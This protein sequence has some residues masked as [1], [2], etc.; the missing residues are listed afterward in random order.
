MFIKLV[1]LCVFQLLAL[2]IFASDQTIAQKQS[3]SQH[4]EKLK[5]HIPLPVLQKIIMDYVGDEYIPTKLDMV[6]RVSATAQS[7]N[8]QYLFIASQITEGLSNTKDTAKVWKFENGKYVLIAHILLPVTAYSSGVAA[9]SDDGKFIAVRDQYQNEDRGNIHIGQLD[10][11]KYIE[12]QIVKN[13]FGIRGLQFFGNTFLGF[14]TQSAGTM[15]L[16]LSQSDRFDLEQEFGERFT[17]GPATFSPDGSYLVI[18]T[19]H[20]LQLWKKI[21]DEFRLKSTRETGT[22][23]N[24]ISISNDNKYVATI[25]NEFAVIY[26]LREDKLEPFQKI[27]LNGYSGEIKFSPDNTYLALA[28]SVPRKSLPKIIIFKFNKKSE[29]YEQIAT[30][31]HD[32]FNRDPYHLIG[33]APNNS[34]ITATV[35]NEITIWENQKEQLERDTGEKAITAVEQEKVTEVD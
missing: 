31:P 18:G 12:K 5:E 29:Q 20:D 25:D 33:F 26:S 14:K 13:A 16:K 3:A 35:G 28:I 9:I 10:N 4:I 8:G 32:V 30:L 24:G 7:P 1:T 6:N 17:S 21:M 11:K 27:E 22:Y 19:Y 2:Q 15:I 23:V 34:I